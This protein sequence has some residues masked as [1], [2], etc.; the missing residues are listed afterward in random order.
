M[1]VSLQHLAERDWVVVPESEAVLDLL[2]CV[3]AEV[4]VDQR[5]MDPF[6]GWVAAAC[7]NFEF[8][9]AIQLPLQLPSTPLP[10]PF[11][12][13]MSFF[14]NY[15]LFH[16]LPAALLFPPPPIHGRALPFPRQPLHSGKVR[17]GKL[18]ERDSSPVRPFP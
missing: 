6:S 14:T 18:C 5:R 12:S 17:R 10:L 1:E 7:H 4:D 3:L 2:D 16:L 15:L 8:L 11:L 13:K 9:P